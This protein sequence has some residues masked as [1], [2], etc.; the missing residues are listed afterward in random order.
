MS[1]DR[2]RFARELSIAEKY[3]LTGSPCM[4]ICE[5]KDGVCTGCHRTKQEIKLWARLS[6][7][8]KDG[9]V[10]RISNH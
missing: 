3:K 5:L 8:E 2:G 7:Q 10:K 4:K 9:I 6:N 1:V